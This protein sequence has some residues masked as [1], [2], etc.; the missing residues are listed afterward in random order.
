[1]WRGRLRRGRGPAA[2]CESPATEERGAAGAGRGE[3][4]GGLRGEGEPLRGEQRA[5]ARGRGGGGSG[6]WGLSGAGE[7]EGDTA[8]ASKSATQGRQTA[9]VALR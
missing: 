8:V 6:R 9:A 5:P 7:G 2:G 4:P 3:S 1:M